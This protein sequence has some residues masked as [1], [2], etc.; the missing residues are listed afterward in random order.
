VFRE[1]EVMVGPSESR[2]TYVVAET[3]LF[4]TLVA[5]IC[6]GFCDGRL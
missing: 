6:T 2:W 5:V 3:L 4:V 1:T